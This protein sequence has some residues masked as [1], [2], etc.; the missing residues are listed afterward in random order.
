MR[1][2]GTAK[3]GQY[4]VWLTE[5]ELEE[6]RRYAA[7]ARDDLIIQL[8][9]YVGL[10]AFEVPQIQPRHVKEADGQ[11]RLDN[12][13]SLYRKP[14]ERPPEHHHLNSNA[15]PGAENYSRSAPPEPG[16]HRRAKRGPKCRVALPGR[17]PQEQGREPPQPISKIADK[18]RHDRSY[19][20]TRTD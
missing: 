18:R 15:N 9:G 19:S 2:E 17:R 13:R 6:L 8:G 1:L 5:D 14:H 12:L 4:K 7:S 3:A 10:R 11:Y 20:V 16:V